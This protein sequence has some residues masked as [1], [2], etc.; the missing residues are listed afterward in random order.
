MINIGVLGFWGFG[1]LGWRKSASW[2][3]DMRRAP[4]AGLDGRKRDKL[5]LEVASGA[6]ESLTRNPS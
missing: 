1:V 6:T 2:S 5:D 3:L 4:G